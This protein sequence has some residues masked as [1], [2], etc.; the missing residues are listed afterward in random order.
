MQ[1]KLIHFLLGA[2]SGAACGVLVR[3]IG[4][5]VLNNSVDL[6]HLDYFLFRT[7][8]IPK[9]WAYAFISFV[10]IGVP[11]FLVARK[12]D[13]LSWFTF[14]WVGGV[15]GFFSSYPVTL[16]LSWAIMYTIAGVAAGLVGYSVMYV[17]AV[18]QKSNR[19]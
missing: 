6:L 15:V 18:H 12:K 14:G 9:L 17:F 8:L 13:R 10:V 1:P 19:E 11:V 5:L 7:L 3:V 16:V 4:G 2:I